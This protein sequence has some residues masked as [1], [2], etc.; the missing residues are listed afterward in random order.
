MFS[1]RAQLGMIEFKFAIIGFLFGL[2][3]AF[4]LV[5]LGSKEILPFK[6]PLVCGFFVPG[7][8]SKKGQL[9]MIEF[10]YFLGGLVVGLIG[11]FIL[12]YL[13]SAAILPFTVPLVCG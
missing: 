2:I 5:F 13:G 4:V 11:G 9:G 12:T 8:L 1:K 10:Q 6:I 7:L 3:G